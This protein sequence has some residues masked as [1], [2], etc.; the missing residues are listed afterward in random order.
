MIANPS[1][2][3]MRRGATA[4][5]FALVAQ[6]FFVLI[7]GMIEIG[8]ACMVTQLLTEAARRAC[9]KGVLEG[10]SS[11][12]IQSAASDYLTSLGI[13]SESIN[14]YINDAPVGSTN[15]AAMP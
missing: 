10:T 15:V 2:R 12:A 7:F 11:S 9:R 4:V 14:V 3:T 5:E 13:S 6:V 1:S 8:R